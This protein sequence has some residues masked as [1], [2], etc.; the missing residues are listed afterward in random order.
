MRAAH[1]LAVPVSSRAPRDG[2]LPL[3][4]APPRPSGRGRADGRPHG[5]QRRQGASTSRRPSR[6][7]RPPLRP[8]GGSFVV[9]RPARA[10]A[11]CGRRPG[12]CHSCSPPYSSHRSAR[13]GSRLRRPPLPSTSCARTAD[14]L[15]WQPPPFAFAGDE[16]AQTGLAV[17]LTGLFAAARRRVPP[18]STTRRA[19]G[20]AR[21]RPQARRRRAS[22]ASTAQTRL[23]FFKLRADKHY[24]LQR[25]PNCVRRL[26]DRKRRAHDLRATRSA[27]RAA[28]RELLPDVVVFAE[29]HG[30]RRSPRSES[31]ARVARSSSRRPPVALL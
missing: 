15:L 19:Q 1:A 22:S 17:Q 8:L 27:R 3:P 12:A 4:A 18:L 26:P 30:L 5:V 28:S 14:L 2:V 13:S 29:E 31:A 21:P 7:K 20:P 11:R 24:L 10:A 25:R 23:S 9:L 6:L 16:L